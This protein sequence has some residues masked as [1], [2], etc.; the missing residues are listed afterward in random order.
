MRVNRVNIR[1][2]ECMVEML[3]SERG[4]WFT[5]NSWHPCKI[6][7]SLTWDWLIFGCEI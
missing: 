1:I 7:S 5:A 6:L 2:N 4:D 3:A